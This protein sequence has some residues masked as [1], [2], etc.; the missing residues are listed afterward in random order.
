MQK[1][2]LDLYRT[3]DFGRRVQKRKELIINQIQPSVIFWVVS[4]THGESFMT[5]GRNSNW[6]PS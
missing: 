5:E 3:L 4:S 1:S 6:R 2:Y